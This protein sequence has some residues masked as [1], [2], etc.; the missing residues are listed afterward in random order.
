MQLQ[1]RSGVRKTTAVVV[2]KRCK[3]IKTLYSHASKSY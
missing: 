1:A 3:F 2:E